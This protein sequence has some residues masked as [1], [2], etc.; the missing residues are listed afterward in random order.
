M[1]VI[2]HENVQKHLAHYH[3]L[4]LGDQFGIWREA[5]E[6]GKCIEI[7]LATKK[8]IVFERDISMHN[9]AGNFQAEVT[10]FRER[11]T[12]NSKGRRRISACLTFF[13]LHS[14]L[15][16]VTSFMHVLCR[17]LFLIL[18]TYKSFYKLHINF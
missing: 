5:F 1:S 11:R 14:Y 2:V 13:A 18:L 3:L 6:G 9:F 4:E 15:T 12:Q 16:Y 10:D 8:R 17:K 7:F